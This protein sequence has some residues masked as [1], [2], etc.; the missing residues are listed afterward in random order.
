MGIFV[1]TTFKNLVASQA[2]SDEMVTMLLDERYSKYTFD[3]N[4]PFLKKIDWRT[5]LSEQRKINGY[6]PPIFFKL[7]RNGKS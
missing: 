4:Y 3:I 6:N 2:L 5:S 1:N 7:I